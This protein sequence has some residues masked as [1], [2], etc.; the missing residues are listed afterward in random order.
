MS[1]PLPRFGACLPHL[2]LPLAVRHSDNTPSIKVVCWVAESSELHR[3]VP[4]RNNTFGGLLSMRCPLG[5]SGHFFS[6]SGMGQKFWPAFAGTWLQM[7][8]HQPCTFFTHVYLGESRGLAALT[9]P[10]RH[11]TICRE[12]HIRL[13]PQI[14]GRYT[15]TLCSLATCITIWKRH[16]RIPG[17]FMRLVAMSSYKSLDTVLTPAQTRMTQTQPGTIHV[18]IDLTTRNPLFSAAQ[19]L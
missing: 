17:R 15:C 19:T 16:M 6:T 8:K 14:H 2:S 1:L 4:P 13:E 7:I 12:P 3:M 18:H 9:P 10:F 11:L 5:E